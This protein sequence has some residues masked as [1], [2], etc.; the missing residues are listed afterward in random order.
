MID[1]KKVNAFYPIL[2]HFASRVNTG[3]ALLGNDRCFA[4]LTPKRLSDLAQD[5]IYLHKVIVCGVK[6]WRGRYYFMIFKK[7]PSDSFTCLNTTF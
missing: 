1:D 6:K 5:G 3:I 2:K 7:T 4:A